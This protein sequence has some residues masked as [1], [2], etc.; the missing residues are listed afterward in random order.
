MWWFSVW[1]KCCLCKTILNCSFTSIVTVPLLHRYSS[2]ICKW[3]SKCQ[4]FY[5]NQRVFQIHW[6][7]ANDLHNYPLW[8]VLPWRYSW[9]SIIHCEAFHRGGI[10]GMHYPLWGVLPWIDFGHALS[11]V[12]RSTVDGFWACIIHCEASTMKV[13][14]ACIIHCEAFYRGWILGMHYPLW[15]FYHGGIV[16]MHYPL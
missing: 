5:N 15:G 2:V 9:A 7:G 13:F 12:R 6:V 1:Y 8:G 14:W 11:T 10:L 3:K 4:L 16:G